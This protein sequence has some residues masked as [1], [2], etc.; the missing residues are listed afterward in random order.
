MA[1]GYI[2]ER[3]GS[4]PDRPG[5]AIYKLCVPAKITEKGEALEG[6][7]TQVTAVVLNGRQTAVVLCACSQD[8]VEVLGPP[9]QC[10]AE[11]LTKYTGNNILEDNSTLSPLE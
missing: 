8:T 7:E 3:I 1:G 9:Q 5:N 10:E 4:D 2:I 6:E 11:Y